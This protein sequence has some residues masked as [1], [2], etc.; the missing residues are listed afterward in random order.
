MHFVPP[1]WMEA[2][3][4]GKSAPFH[5]QDS[6]EN[7]PIVWFH[8]TCLNINIATMFDKWYCI[9]ECRYEVMQFLSIS[10]E[11]ITPR[12]IPVVQK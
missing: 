5:V 12:M 10:M 4:H 11:E 6:D 1:S 2:P 3:Y 9:T 7:Y 8:F